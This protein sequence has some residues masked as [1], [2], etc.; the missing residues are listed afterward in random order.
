ML[1]R[2]PYVALATLNTT[3]GTARN[4]TALTTEFAAPGT[5]AV[6]CTAAITTASV[7]AT[8]KLQVSVDGTTYV[9]VS[10]GTASNTTFATAAG[11]GSEVVTVKVL[12]FDIA[13][14][15]FVLCRVVAT[16]SGAT[17]FA[18]DTTAATMYY[19]PAGK[20]S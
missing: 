6:V 12:S 10:G 7:L 16:L 5:I 8:F 15:A 13:T 9:D 18:A 17:T 4:G 20:L 2:I 14:H 3:N 1:A 11:T 19:V